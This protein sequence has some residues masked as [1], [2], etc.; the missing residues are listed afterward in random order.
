MDSWSAPVGLDRAPWGCR[1]FLERARG[2][3]SR[4]M[5]RPWIPGA[6]PWGWTARHGA[7]VDSW[8][9]PVGLDRA[10]W[11]GRGFLER[12]RGAGPRAMAR[13][14]IPGARPWGWTARHGAAVDSW[15][16]SVGL[17]RAPWRGRGFLERAHGA[18]SRAMPGRGFLERAHGAAV[19]FVERSRAPPLH[20]VTA[21]PHSAAAG[22][23]AAGPSFLR[24]FPISCARSR[25]NR[26]SSVMASRRRSS[27][28]ALSLRST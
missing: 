28:A 10:P 4:A 3:G 5:E 12:A 25:S 14:W 9:A 19:D 2:A 18:G 27:P 7:A 26:S 20:R 17:D 23:N 1:G 24:I 21:G 6:R 22:T 15:S 13:P 8:S 16:A 11:R